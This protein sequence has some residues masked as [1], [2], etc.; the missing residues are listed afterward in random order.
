MTH[1]IQRL[2]RGG[3]VAPVA[4]AGGAPGGLG[5]SATAVAVA[6]VSADGD[7]ADIGGLLGGRG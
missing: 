1:P 6:G 7:V 4:V 5:G 3:G 2:R